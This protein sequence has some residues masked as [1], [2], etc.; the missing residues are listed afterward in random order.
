[1]SANFAFPFITR[2]KKESIH[3]DDES[4]AIANISAGIAT[5]AI[6]LFLWVERNDLHADLSHVPKWPWLVITGIGLVTLHFTLVSIWRRSTGHWLWIVRGLGF[7]VYV[8]AFATLALGFNW[9]LAERIFFV[10]VEGRV[11]CESFTEV[12]LVEDQDVIATSPI[13]MK[14]YRFLLRPNEIQRGLEIRLKLSGPGVIVNASKGSLPQLGL[15]FPGLGAS[16]PD[17]SVG[18]SSARYSA[19]VAAVP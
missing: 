4:R 19:A 9:A 10:P 12:L 2:L 3:F 18:G 15:D 17:G 6:V 1:M 11:E 13:V 16:C 7:C 5:S 14:R 8:G